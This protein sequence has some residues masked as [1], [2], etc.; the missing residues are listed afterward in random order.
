MQNV[1]TYTGDISDQHMS[2]PLLVNHPSNLLPASPQTLQEDLIVSDSSSDVYEP[3]PASDIHS[4]LESDIE[5]VADRKRTILT[6][7]TPKNLTKK[8]SMKR[9]RNEKLWQKNVK[10]VKRL[11]GESYVG[12]RGIEVP[13]RPLLPAP[14]LNKQKHKCATI[15]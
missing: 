5:G 8:E 7:I 4:S 11:K 1:Q 6:D 3:S 15:V 12:Y 2:T 13:S 9:K 10:K 14:C